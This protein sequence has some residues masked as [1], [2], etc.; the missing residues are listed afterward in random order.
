MRVRVS[1]NW[2]ISF[3]LIWI[4][5]S[6]T[7]LLLLAYHLDHQEKG[8]YEVCVI[9]VVVVSSMGTHSLLWNLS[10]ATMLMYSNCR[11]SNLAISVAT[12]WTED[13][14]S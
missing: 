4:R 12:K 7:L 9:V 14:M 6:Q 13:M 8:F 2:S 10:Q 1:A 11:V 5:G 3:N